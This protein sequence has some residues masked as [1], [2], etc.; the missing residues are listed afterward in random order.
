M[1]LLLPVT[2]A[3]ANAQVEAGADCI[4]ICDHASADLCSPTVYAN[5]LAPIHTRLAEEIKIPLI[6]HICGN[7]RDRIKKIVDT[8]LN[9][10]HWDTKSGTPEQIRK[11]AGDKLALMGGINNKSLLTG[12]PE[13]ISWQSIQAQR[14]GI[15]IIGPECA[16]PLK[17][18]LRNL[19]AIKPT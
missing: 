11:L 6:L 18:P 14:A 19:K 2:I 9:C 5:F 12:S 17:T 15:D 4:L 1:E 16:I 7:T 10:F 8:R 3:F 13:D